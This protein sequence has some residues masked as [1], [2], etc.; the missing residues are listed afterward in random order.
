[1]KVSDQIIEAARTH[2]Y[3]L[4]IAPLSDAVV[5]RVKEV[6]T[7]EGF[8]VETTIEPDTINTRRI[9]IARN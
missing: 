5:A 3:G 1:M 2:G 8:T 9:E 4:V 6:L 7:A